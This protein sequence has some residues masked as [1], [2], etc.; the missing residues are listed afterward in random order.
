MKYKNNG[1]IFDFWDII[2][3]IALCTLI[4]L[5][6]KMNKQISLKLKMLKTNND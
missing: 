3:F 4:F 1:F 5:L 6:K 2:L